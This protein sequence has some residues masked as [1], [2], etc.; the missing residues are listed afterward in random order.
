MKHI[1]HSAILALL[2][3]ALAGLSTPGPARAVS[4]P[5]KTAV[6][7]TLEESARAFETSD[8]PALERVWATDEDLTV[9]EGGSV[10][11]GWTDYRDH[12][13]VPEMKEMK[14]VSYR[15]RDIA[16]RVA[17]GT[18]WATFE[19]DIS[20]ATEKGP[21]KSGGLGTAILEKRGGNWRIVHWHSSAKPRK[22]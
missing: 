22:R 7:A 6:I 19:Y 9:F 20:G 10:N 17:G 12:H 5:E 18:A 11:R 13:L 3:L 2:T 21:F 1:R 16:P 14:N 8:L 4:D 15:L